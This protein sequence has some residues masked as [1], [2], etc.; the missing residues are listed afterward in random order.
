[1]CEKDDCHSNNLLCPKLDECPRKD[2]GY[3]DSTGPVSAAERV[4]VLSHTDLTMPSSSRI[5]EN[6]RFWNMSRSCLLKLSISKPSN[7]HTSHH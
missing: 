2:T 7:T 3:F 6:P 5:S 1:M 4:V